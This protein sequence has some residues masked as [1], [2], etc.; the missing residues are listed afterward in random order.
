LPLD[1]IAEVPRFGDWKILAVA[2]AAGTVVIRC[3]VDGNVTLVD[4][5][6]PVFHAAVVADPI[7]LFSRNAFWFR[8]VRYPFMVCHAL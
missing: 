2:D 6:R 1:E 4:V 8:H 7:G 3:A 5:P